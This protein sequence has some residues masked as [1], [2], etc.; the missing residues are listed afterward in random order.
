MTEPRLNIEYW[1]SLYPVYTNYAEGYEEA[2]SHSNLVDRAEG[3]WEW[4][5][6]NLRIP[7]DTIDTV[8]EKLDPDDY[9]TCEPEEA[10]ES[11]S[12]QLLE[13]EVVETSSL[14]TSAFLL[15]L[16]A[17]GPNHYSEEFPIYDVRVWNAYVYLW[18]IRGEGEQLYAGASNS[19]TKYAE[20]CSEFSQTCPDGKA[21]DYE[22]ALFMFGGFIRKISSTD[23]TPIEKIDAVLE[24]QEQALTDT[25]SAE[26]YSL[27]DLGEVSK[28]D[29]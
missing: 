16:M 2:M 20:F 22:R 10:I 8:I 23:P 5:G 3:F 1:K 12:E 17:S 13:A 11:L 21:R 19:A 4:K 24:R 25:Q 28:S 15:H 6:L 14:V 26:N 7:F 9:I 18:R 29:Q 27:V